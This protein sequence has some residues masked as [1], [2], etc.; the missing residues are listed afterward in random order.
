[1]FRAIRILSVILLVA[2]SKHS[3]ISQS[4]VPGVVLQGPQTVYQFGSVW[5]SMPQ[6][7]A[8]QKRLVQLGKLHRQ[9]M[10]S[11][12]DKLL[13]LANAL[14]QQTQSGSGDYPGNGEK[15]KQIEKLARQV[16]SLMEDPISNP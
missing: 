12:V 7:L 15:A 3:G 5:G 10:A 8:N 14:Q 4:G 11:D 13:S 1:M 2:N 9:E 16:R 6:V